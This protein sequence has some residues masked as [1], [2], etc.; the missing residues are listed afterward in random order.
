MKS[1]NR[2]HTFRNNK[3][4][5]VCIYTVPQKTSHLWLVI[6][7]THLNGVIYFLAEML[8]IK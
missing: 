4:F 6:T 2:M 1:D 5:K 3:H 8:P 7:L